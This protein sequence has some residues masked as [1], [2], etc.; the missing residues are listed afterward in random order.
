MSRSP[1]PARRAL[2][3]AAE[4]LFAEG[5]VGATTVAAVTRAA[6]QGNKSAVAFHYRDKEGLVRAVL[7]KHQR[8]IDKRR[9][10][11]LDSGAGFVEALVVPPAERLE[12]PDGGGE[13]LRIQAEMTVRRGPGPDT[14]WSGLRRPD[15]TADER[16]AFTETLISSMTKILAD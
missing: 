15:F 4:K 8:R 9:L 1:Q 11:L 2:V 10:E 16:V 5:G 13:Y 14:Q 12:D 6:G 3:S 7:A